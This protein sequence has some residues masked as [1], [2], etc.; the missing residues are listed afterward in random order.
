[1][2]K[3]KSSISAFFILL[4][5]S[6]FVN[7]NGSIDR[8]TDLLAQYHQNFP[9][10]KIHVHVDRGHYMAGDTVYFRAYVANAE[11][12]ALAD[13]SKILYIDLI[14]E[15]DG[16]VNSF[17]YP[18][19]GGLSSGS[20]ELS[21]SLMSGKYTLTAY[22]GWMRNFAADFFS[23]TSINIVG[24]N[25][26]P[27]KSASS[28]K[29]HLYNIQFF[30]E[31]GQLVEQQ[32]SVIGFKVINGNGV[33]ENI[34]GSVLDN[35]ENVITTFNAVSAGIGRFTLKPLS[36]H[37]YK[38]V[39]KTR[40]GEVKTL[41]LPKAAASGYTLAANQSKSEITIT[42]RKSGQALSDAVSI[43]AQAANKLITLKQLKLIDNVAEVKLP[44]QDFPNGITQITL[45]DQLAEPVAERLVFVKKKNQLRLRLSQLDKATQE[46]TLEVTDELSNPVSGEFSIA[47][48]EPGSPAE[49]DDRPSILADLF[50][51]S[52]L[53]DHI[54]NPN[55]YINSDEPSAS[56]L[57][58]NLM[59]TQ[60]WQRFKWKD[61]ISGNNPKIIYPVEQ[62]QTLAGTLSLK[63]GTPV[64]EGKVL[65]TSYGSAGFGLNTRTD[66][67]GRFIFKLPT[68]TGVQ[69][70]KLIGS[71]DKG[72]TNVGIALD[73][74]KPAGDK[75]SSGRLVIDTTTDGSTG[76]GNDKLSA[77]QQ[78][79]PKNQQ[80]K[81]VL[82][83]SKK[84]SLKEKALQPSAN[85]NGPGN[86]DQVITYKDLD[87]CPN[88]D[89]CLQGK[90]VGVFFRTVRDPITK[91]ERRLAFSSSGMNKPMMIVLDG[92]P[93]LGND[94]S[95]NSIPAGDVQTIEVLRSGAKLIAYGMEASGGV[96]LITTKRGGID[97]NQ[98]G[99]S[100]KQ[101][102]G[103]L[104]ITYNGYHKSR[105]FYTDNRN[106]KTNRTI[107]WKPTIRTD[108]DGKA[109]ISLKNRIDVKK[110]NVI[111]EG[112]SSEGQIGYLQQQ[113]TL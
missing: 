30:P 108:E 51:T 10:E 4:I 62:V 64:K 107:L 78:R 38:A 57:I 88:L 61:L 86:A 60:T 65:L 68:L 5:I 105:D 77:A 74:L 1:M 47:I 73:E 17:N 87:N 55:H 79:L 41:P 31:G 72:S 97:Y 106:K 81:E 98:A 100:Q 34:S 93:I 53:K 95:I 26:N 27:V 70:F 12:N 15:A 22:T 63:D 14:N 36:G 96:L 8:I 46:M 66:D 43:L 83:Q 59:L 71:T 67:K 109:I 6:A 33:G 25:N 37:T 16:T 99:D 7:S 80:L 49:D 85:L 13:T 19:N 9:Q 82:V 21:D 91:I 3:I 84:I 32:S 89:Q 101:V 20:F 90:L 44:L 39:I 40:N 28:G 23:K 2:L 52:D 113:Q 111:I 50:L 35:S 54:E 94:A 18:L 11:S 42:V 103:L 58:D 110:I 29:E 112:I 104:S 76:N 102:S 56:V 48:T 69:Q 75:T 92:V 24:I 45:F